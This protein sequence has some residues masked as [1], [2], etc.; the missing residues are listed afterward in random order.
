MYQNYPL[1]LILIYKSSLKTLF[2]NSS[3]ESKKGIN[4]GSKMFCSEPEWRYNQT[5]YSNSALLVR[6]AL[7]P[8]FV[9][10]LR[11][12]GSQWNIFEQH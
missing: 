1:A 9:Q 5:L 7:S 3:A 2:H 4:T 6:R 10:Q 11:P 8:V 12:S